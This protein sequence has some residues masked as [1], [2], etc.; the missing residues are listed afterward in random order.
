MTTTLPDSSGRRPHLIKQLSRKPG[1]VMT[2]EARRPAVD[3]RL[4]MAQVIE[5]YI[6]VR[7][8]PKVKW[9]PVEQRGKIIAFPSDL[10]KSA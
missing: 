5:F 9:V 7:F 4:V 10:K 2:Q 6:P 3:R 1:T 8:K